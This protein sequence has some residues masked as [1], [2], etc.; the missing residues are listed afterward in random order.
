MLHDEAEQW[1]EELDGGVLCTTNFNWRGECE[2]RRQ[3]RATAV[4]LACAANLVGK[5]LGEWAQVML[6]IK[7]EL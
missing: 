3:W 2:P 1:Q 6:G 7:V 4:E 5:W